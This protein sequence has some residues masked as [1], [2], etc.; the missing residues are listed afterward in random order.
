[1][2]VVATSLLI[3]CVDAET[4]DL[5]AAHKDT[6]GLCMRAGQQ[7]LVVRQEQEARFRKAA[8]QLGYGIPV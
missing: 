1:M 4:A 5:I 3:E 2:K 6:A 8:R 7:H